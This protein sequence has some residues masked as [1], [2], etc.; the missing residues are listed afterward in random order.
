MV[1]NFNL[2]FINKNSNLIF[3]FL[4]W[5]F[6][7]GFLIKIRLEEIWAKLRQLRA[8]KA[9]TLHQPIR[10]HRIIWNGSTEWRWFLWRSHFWNANFNHF[11]K[12]NRI[13]VATLKL[14]KYL[15]YYKLQ[16]KCIEQNFIKNLIKPF[17]SNEKVFK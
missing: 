9:L 3:S 2:N 14:K 1:G 7:G 17:A 5:R 12:I 8:K 16:K 15:G 11:N 10:I 4:H 13:T 6:F